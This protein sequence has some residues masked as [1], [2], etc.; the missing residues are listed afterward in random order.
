MKVY[1]P[2]TAPRN[3]IEVEQEIYE[4]IRAAQPGFPRASLAEFI[5]SVG[6]VVENSAEE[7]KQR[8]LDTYVPAVHESD[9]DVD[10]IQDVLVISY[11][12]ALDGLELLRLFCLQ[13]PHVDLQPG[14]HCKE[15]MM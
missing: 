15:G 1:G 9:P 14:G 2:G 12:A 3:D 5:S 13:N 7:D 10:Y 8:T 4:C 6:K 11:K